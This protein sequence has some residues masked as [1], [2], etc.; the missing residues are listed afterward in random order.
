MHIAHF[1]H[2]FDSIRYSVLWNWVRILAS[3]AALNTQSHIN[4]TKMGEYCPNKILL[5]EL[6]HVQGHSSSGTEIQ[7]FWSPIYL[8][9]ICDLTS[10]LGLK[11]LFYKLQKENTEEINKEIKSFF[12]WR[13][14]GDLFSKFLFV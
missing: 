12:K 1:I 7:I 3:T 8:F 6:K 11:L 9:E 14:V 10:N 4:Y 5:L 13:S 2:I